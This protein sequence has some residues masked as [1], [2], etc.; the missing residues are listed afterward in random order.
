MKHGS[1]S[2]IMSIAMLKQLINIDMKTGLAYSRVGQD[3]KAKKRQGYSREC[4]S[5]GRRLHIELGSK[6]SLTTT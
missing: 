4:K 1:A 5:G 6:P 3:M 2:M